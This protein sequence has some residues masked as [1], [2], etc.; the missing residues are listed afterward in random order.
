MSQKNIK[1]YFSKSNPDKE[2][3]SSDS[4]SDDNYQKYL[5]PAGDI[6]YY[7]DILK[8]NQ[9]L[10]KIAKIVCE[11]GVSECWAYF[12]E[13][14]IGTKKVLEKYKF[15]KECFE[16]E[17][18][19]LKAFSKTTSTSNLLNHLRSVHD[20][21][22]K[23]INY[24][25]NNSMTEK[26]LNPKFNNP[27]KFQ[28]A[29]R[30]A[31]MCCID[32][33]PFSIVEREGFQKYLKF[34]DPNINFPSSYTVSST[35][36]NDVY[37]VYYNHVQT[38][39]KTSPTN[40]TLVLDM[41]SD[42]YKR[43]SYINFK[44]H[45][46]QNFEMQ[47]ITLKTEIFPRPHTSSAVSTKIQETIVEFG[48]ENK[49]L[50]AVT[51]GGTNIIAALKKENIVRYGCLA[52]ALHRFLMHDVLNEDSFKHI[53]AIIQKL[54]GIFR[55][56][57][58]SSEEIGK[59]HNLKEQDELTKI[60]IESQ[61]IAQNFEYEERF[62]VGDDN[63]DNEVE[64]ALMF[65]QHASLKNS[66]PTRWNS[67]LEML[68]SFLKNIDI[69]NIA[70]LRVKK[71]PLIIPE[72]EKEIIK[73]FCNY[74]QIFE[75]GTKYLQGQKYPTVSA[76]IYFYES[77]ISSLEKVEEDSCFDLTIKLCRFSKV[78]LRK[79]FKLMKIH[80][81]AAILDPCQKNWL[82]LDNYVKKISKFNYVQNTVVLDEDSD[83]PIS[84]EDLL[85]NEI[86]RMKSDDERP[87]SSSSIEPCRK[88]NKLSDSRQQML[89]FVSNSNTASTKD[90]IKIEVQKYFAVEVEEIESI[91]WWHQ[92]KYV[93]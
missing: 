15:C 11:H 59:L 88:R 21:N 12:G 20:K 74:L 30:L 56:L 71:D 39:L 82:V 83:F 61:Y 6:S 3:L 53:N 90:S 80:L 28:H 8:R 43:L 9:D 27:N 89:A 10:K 67:L 85:I 26:A 45:F 87:C 29:R 33:Q 70:L 68:R 35:A 36:L 17:N 22:L 93:I 51:D 54:K 34:Y 62:A 73:E 79:R 64:K 14:Y 77:I 19:K 40:M 78:N 69:I 24:N 31:E 55:S 23:S 42:R 47:V 86:K 5:L 48:L 38:I 32:L 13:L 46:C 66:V 76:C 16:E 41:W 58:Y 49:E 91:D 18:L 1:N 92:N 44:F 50:C 52:H 65:N 4:D 81:L 60:L 84:K 72:M 7:N 63:F 75:D 37:N 2:I 25:K 57:M